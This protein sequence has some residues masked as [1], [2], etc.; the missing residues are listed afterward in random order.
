MQPSFIAEDHPIVETGQMLGLDTF[1]SPTLSD[2]AL[3]SVPSVK[4]GPEKYSAFSHCG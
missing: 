3:L 4:I 2:Q 1:G